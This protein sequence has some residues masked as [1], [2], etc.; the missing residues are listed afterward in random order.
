MLDDFSNEDRMKL[1]YYCPEC[2][3]GLMRIK[4]ITYFTWLNEELITVPNFPAWVCDLCGR[5]DYDSR[6]VSWLNMMLH[7]ETGKKIAGRLKFPKI[8]SKSEIKKP[9]YPDS[10]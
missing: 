8:S 9:I 1:V 7:P 4:Y 5:R 10:S 2:Q 6:A 3:L